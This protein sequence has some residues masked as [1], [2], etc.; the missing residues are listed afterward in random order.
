MPTKKILISAFACDPY[1][2]SDEE[3][4]WQWATELSSRGF[5]VTVLTRTSHQHD[6]ENGIQE[7]KKCGNVRFEYV[8]INW[9]HN[10]L[11]RVNRRNHIYYY[12]WQIV[13][14]FRARKLHQQCQFDLIHHVTWVSFR[15]PSFMGLVGAPFYFGPVA[16]GDEIP[17]GYTA[18]FS[19][20]QK[21]LEVV[22]RFAN[23]LIRFDPLMRLTFATASRV[24]FTS[25]GHLLR[26]PA[27]V[28]AKSSIEL[29]IGCDLQT[30]NVP[31][32]ST[33]NAK[34]GDRLLFA[35][36]CIGWKGMDIG[37][38]IFAEVHKQMPNV[39]LTIVGDGVDRARWMEKANAMGLHDAIKWHGWL[40]KA[41]VQKLYSQYDALFYPSLRDSGGFVVLEALQNSLPV[42]CFKLGGPGVIVNNTCGEAVTASPDID[43]TINKFAAAVVRVL[44]LGKTSHD[45][46]TPCQKRVENFTWEAL[47]QRIYAQLL[48][49]SKS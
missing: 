18:D 39:T 48:G 15:Q 42:V 44:Q 32:L 37:L 28:Q 16:G 29:G 17:N 20:K 8:D 2:G 31:N 23:A 9:L 6:I 14:Y 22:R 4:G 45:W 5:D 38:R 25:E 13:A 49:P 10:I 11:K 7:F 1:F 21:L 27:S 43:D 24:F 3:V 30:A 36:R 12:V 19:S 26:V 35:G 47:I 46:V 41:E 33:P 40:D 34:Q